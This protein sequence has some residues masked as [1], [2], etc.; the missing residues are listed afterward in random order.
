M[1]NLIEILS[2]WAVEQGSKIAYTYLHDDGVRTENITYKQLF[3]KVQVIGNQLINRKISGER[4]LLLYPSGLDYIGAFLGCLYAGVVAV[5][6]YPPRKNRSI[7]RILAIIADAK[8]AITLSTTD[9]GSD[10]EKKIKEAGIEHLAWLTTDAMIFPAEP[11][12]ETPLIDLQSL[13]FLQYTSGSTGTP[14]GVMVSHANLM[15]NQQMIQQAFDANQDTVLVGWLPLYHDMGLIGN[16]LG[17]LYTGGHAVLMSPVAFLQKPYRWLHAISQYKATHSGAPDF[18]Y[19]LCVEKI[20]PEQKATLDLSSWR[21]AYNGAEPI[22]AATLDRFDDAFAGCGFQKESFYPC[23]GMA[24]A[25]LFATG[26]NR[27]ML[28]LIRTLSAAALEQNTAEWS[29]QDVSDARTLNLVGCGHAWLG[30]DVRVVH[31]DTQISCLEGEIGELWI[32]GPSVAQGYWGQPDRTAETFQA[33]LH[34]P[35]ETTYLRT[36]DL[37]FFKEGQFFITGRLKDLII[38]RGRNHYPQDIERTAEQAHRALRPTCGAAFSVTRDGQERLVIVQ[39]LKREAMP[40]LNAAQVMQAIRQQVAVQHEVPIDQ[41]VLIRTGSIPKTS[42]GKIQRN[43]CRQLFL[44]DSLEKIAEWSADTTDI[45]VATDTMS[46]EPT[47]VLAVPTQAALQNWLA[48]QIARHV[49]L[50]LSQIQ[51][52]E[53]FDSYGLDSLIAVQLSGELSEWLGKPVSPT[54]VYDFPNI[55]ALAR[56]L[57]QN[58][59]A[60]VESEQPMRATEACPI[61]VVGMA[62][63]FPGAPDLTAFWELLSQGK[64]AITRTPPGR[65]DAALPG[66]EAEAVHWG[67]FLP[68]VDLFD[69]DF[70]GISPREAEKIDPQQRMLMEV[71][72]EAFEQAGIAPKTLAGK[73]VGVF[74]GISSNDYARLPQAM[75]DLD[76]YYGTGNAGSIAANRLSYW[77]DFRGPSVAVDTACSSSLV[78][79]HQA[80]Q[81][82]QQGESELVVAGG[83]NLLLHPDLFVVFARAGM[84]ASDGRCKVF[85]AQANGYVRGEGCGVVLLKRLDDAVRDNDPILAVIKGSAINQDGKS[86]GLTAPNGPAQQAV[87]RQALH[88]AHLQPADVC[89]VEGHGTGTPLGDPIEI[90]ALQQVLSENRQPEQVCYIH[91]VKTNIGHLEA[92]AGMAGL[93]KTVLC[94]QHQCVVPHLHLHTLNPQIPLNQTLFHIPTMVIPLPASAQPLVAGVSAF[95]FGGTNAHLILEQ[96]VASKI[97]VP[98]PVYQEGQLCIWQGHTQEALQE[99]VRKTIVFLDNNPSLALYDLAATLATG[100]NPLPFRLA[101]VGH[102]LTEVVDKLRMYLNEIPT[103]GLHG[104]HCGA[105]KPTRKVFVW[106]LPTQSVLP[107]PIQIFNPSFRPVV[108]QIDRTT[109]L[110]HLGWLYTHGYTVDWSVVYPRHSFQRLSLSGYPFQRTRH[111]L[112]HTMAFAPVSPAHTMLSEQF[113]QDVLEKIHHTAALTAEEQGYAQKLLPV[114]AGHCRQEQEDEGI[115]KDLYV[116]TWEHQPLDSTLATSAREAVWVVLYPVP[117]EA[118]HWQLP[119]GEQT[120]TYIHVYAGTQFEPCTATHWTLDA[121]QPSHFQQLFAYLQQQAIQVEGIVYVWPDTVLGADLSS[122]TAEALH[123]PLTDCC[124]FLYL[125]QGYVATRMKARRLVVVTQ[126]AQNL[127]QDTSLSVHPGQAVAWGM[128]KVISLE[129]PDLQTVLLDID[130]FNDRT[131]PLLV[132]ELL[133]ASDET[134]LAFRNGQRY[135]ARLSA[136]EVKPPVRQVAIEPDA[137]Y[138]ITG[139]TGALGVEL[140]R[141][142]VVR[143]ARHVCWVVRNGLPA[144]LQETV[145]QWK[146]E[147]V[148]LVVWQADIADQNQLAAALTLLTQEA[149]PHPLKGIFHMAGILE[150][151]FVWNQ[152]P[153]TFA[154]VFRSK[155]QGGWNLH[156]LTQALSLDWFVCFSSAASLL[157]SPG[158]AN[159]AAANAFLDAL[160]VFRQQAGLPALSLQWGPWQGEGMAA[161]KDITHQSGLQKINPVQGWKTLEYSWQRGI[162]VVACLPMDQSRAAH[163]LGNRPFWRSVFPVA[164]ATSV[165]NHTTPFRDTLQQASEAQR[166]SLLETHLRQTVAQVL[167]LPLSKLPDSTTGFADMG[168][169]SLMAVEVKNI[170][171]KELAIPLSATVLFNYPTI[172]ELVSYLLQ[173]MG[174]PL[175]H[176]TEKAPTMPVSKTEAIDRTEP[177][178]IVGAG[179]R[180]PGGVS[181]L[182]SLWS[183]LAEGKNALVEVPMQRWDTADYFDPVPG[184]PGKMYTRQGGFLDQIDGFDADFFGIAPREV[185]PMDPQQRLLLEVTWEALEHAGY[186]PADIQTCQTGIFVGIGQNEYAP[187]VAGSDA[188]RVDAYVGTGNGACFSAG[189]LSYIL[190]V[191][192]PSM[193]LDTACSSSLVSIHLAC[194]SLRNGECDIALAG[195]VQ[196]MVSPATQLFLSQAQAL[197]PTGKCHTFSSEADGYVRGEGCGMVV[198]KPL[199]AAVRD[200]DYILGVIKGS[201]VNHDGRSSGLTVPNG[202]AQMQVIEKALRQATILPQEISY[203]EAHG[204]GTALGDPIELEALGNVLGINRQTPLWVGSIK[205]NIGHLEAAAGIAGLLKIV[206]AMQHQAIPAHLNFHSPNRLIDWKKWPV[207]I[208]VQMTP[209]PS[210]SDKRRAGV[211]S[212]GLSG[213]NAHVI[214]E[215]YVPIPAAA[216]DGPERPCHLLVLSAKSPAALEALAQQYATWLQ[217]HPQVALADVV[218]TASTGRSHWTHRLALKA[219]TTDELC[220]QLNAYLSTGLQPANTIF[221]EQ[222]QAGNVVFVCL[223]Y[224]LP[225]TDRGHGLFQTEPAFRQ[226]ILHCHTFLTETFQLSL[227]GVLYPDA[228]VD[229]SSPLTHAATFALEYALGQLWLSWGVQPKQI[230]VHGWGVYVGACLAGILSVEDALRLVMER[231]RLRHADPTQVASLQIS[232]QGVCQQLTFR[233]ATVILVSVCTQAPEQ[234]AMQQASYWIQHGLSP[235]PPFADWPER[236]HQEKGIYLEIGATPLPTEWQHWMCSPADLWIDGLREKP[237]AIEA[238]LDGLGTLYTAGGTINWK[239][240][241]TGQIWQKTA[242]PT[243]PFQRKSYWVQPPDTQG[244]IGLSEPVVSADVNLYQTVYIEKPLAEETLLSPE[245]IA[246]RY[247]L[248]CSNQTDTPDR[249]ALLAAATGCTLVFAFL[250][251]TYHQENATRFYLHPAQAEDFRQLIEALAS[252]TLQGV[253]Y[254]WGIDSERFV[255]GKIS[256]PV[257]VEACQGLLHLVQALSS[258]PLRMPPRLLIVTR[259]AVQASTAD[260]LRLDVSPLT[261]MCKSIQLEHPEWQVVWAD[262]A[263]NLLPLDVLAQEFLTANPETQLAYRNGKRLAGRLQP[264]AL[265]EETASFQIDTTA[266]YLIT[267]ATGALGKHLCAWLIGQGARHL[268]VIHRSS[269]AEALAAL[270][271]ELALHGGTLRIYQADVAD[272]TAMKDVFETLQ[273][274]GISLKG[275]FHLAGTRMDRTIQNLTWNDFTAV[276]RSKVQG[277]WNLHLLTQTLSLDWFVCFSSA[278][279]LLGSPGQANYAAANA[280]LDALAVF[281]RQAGLPALSIQWGPWQGE[282]MAE[283]ASSHQR[284]GAEVIQKTSAVHNLLRLGQVLS[285]SSVPPVIGMVAFNPNIVQELAAQFSFLSLVAE[286]DHTKVAGLSDSEVTRFGQQLRSL[287]EAEARRSLFRFIGETTAHILGRA[288]TDIL[289]PSQGLA[290]AGLDSLMAVELQRRIQQQVQ[291]SFSPAILYSYNTLQSLT[292]YVFSLLMAETSVPLEV[293]TPATYLKPMTPLVSTL[294][295]DQLTEEEAEALLLEK[296]EEMNL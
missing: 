65:W 149:Y 256:L 205:T 55:Q 192:G 139:G 60:S 184:T 266:S 151:A 9:I 170:L 77:Y 57:S 269:A 1:K 142:L 25:T 81:S 118:C 194:Q 167:R 201:A 207:Q 4:A 125:I 190:G 112:P 106:K 51:L 39:E 222:V 186:T 37:G 102:T 42:S 31:P 197:S 275:V 224:T 133:H 74:I 200:K 249:Y 43:A 122:V 251:E 239:T 270:A 71:S 148:S 94:L 150:D 8:P 198:L 70:F 40:H 243:Y 83:V 262:V 33:Q 161:G 97:S 68:S 189:R 86:N 91:S 293:H 181:D 296:L 129:I 22:H 176:A 242:L 144:H 16:V 13:A 291:V 214:L 29:A 143:G 47:L 119:V 263:D 73:A 41:I 126:Q 46:A 48:A 131:V 179:C 72:W 283:D 79:V 156:L 135:V 96:A 152:T 182:E 217:V 64:D 273:T 6:V 18:A 121:T 209:W 154:S 109:R 231:S 54:V 53:P 88:K 166:L 202:N 288:A 169:D 220:A 3:A 89:M 145:A 295:I 183:L 5:P 187:L 130:Q 267:G 92:A 258:V 254:E 285:V 257:Q 225:Y 199:S 34:P 218:Y 279:S 282:G 76:A 253:W 292:D 107:N 30:Q 284:Q 159:Y 211:S 32:S 15:H 252:Y 50:P 67:G 247:I 75:P 59:T 110:S 274:D 93:I 35:T 289:P 120:L 228:P 244:E 49:Q 164:A 165:D 216:S 281:R 174:L 233:K 163:L 21:I 191:H 280:F 177:I 138:L 272:Y 264:Y 61:A 27:K 95:G 235:D 82:L 290:E 206:V 52:D 69:A 237:S 115:R 63:R 116:Q 99:L 105:Q 38:V 23:Y 261:G 28:P 238:L 168:L 178:A 255:T 196:L 14:K 10:S 127:P 140:T 141:W 113:W 45:P 232:F 2:H 36:G 108:W 173:E 124:R 153:D 227:L 219:H 229:I 85:D 210:R 193:A 11:V 146:I 157:G 240:F 19:S 250:G 180:F 90:Q 114:L 132:A 7:E 268:I 117:E 287:S 100:R 226:A 260:P 271:D 56:H 87:I 212:F 147:G 278:A 208:P 294:D 128:G 158:Q 44:Q 171:E 160:A 259:Q 223:G 136:V 58:P 24:E 248:V 104:H 66:L 203:V 246:G 80:C 78:A 101:V 134:Q 241:A 17:S 213:T 234:E 162:P 137:T 204:T 175:G 265:P 172:Q 188:T 155:V 286:S 98:S 221:R 185:L 236:P 111:W 103:P 123:T 195:G 20:T 84:L 215:E 12:W 277:G 276:F 26:G 245:K 230:V 62:C